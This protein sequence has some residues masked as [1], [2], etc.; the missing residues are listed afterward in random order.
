M[1]TSSK[2]K[3]YE[4]LKMGVGWVEGEFDSQD[5]QERLK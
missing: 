1:E 5:G 2:D 3:N 4:V